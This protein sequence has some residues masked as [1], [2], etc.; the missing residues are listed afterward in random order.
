MTT[1]AGPVVVVI[2][3]HR[4]RRPDPFINTADV[5]GLYP[6]DKAAAASRKSNTWKDDIV[7]NDD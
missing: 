6:E 7:M 4:D 3:R 5:V 1:D 2:D